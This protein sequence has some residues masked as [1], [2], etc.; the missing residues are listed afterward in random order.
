MMCHSLLP[1][2][3]KINIKLDTRRVDKTY[4]LKTDAMRKCEK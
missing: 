4:T 2:L 1:G 3:D